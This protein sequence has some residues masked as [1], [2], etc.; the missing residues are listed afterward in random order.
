MTAFRLLIWCSWGLRPS[1]MWRRIA[2]VWHFTIQLIFKG[3]ISSWDLTFEMRLPHCLGTSGMW[4]HIPEKWRPRFH[5]FILTQLIIHTKK[6][7]KMQQCIKIYYSIFMWSSTCFGRHTAH[8][9]EPK[10]ALAA[11]GFAYVESCWTCGC[12]TA[13]SNHTSNNFPCMQNQRLLVQF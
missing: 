6:S 4:C 12:W 8:H 7:N 10:T 9:Q 13:S 5:T 2:D 1:G 11:S 3:L